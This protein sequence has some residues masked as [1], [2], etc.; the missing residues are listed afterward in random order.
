[1]VS[2]LANWI[3]LDAHFCFLCCCRSA[4]VDGLCLVWLLLRRQ[5]RNSFPRSWGF[6]LPSA[7]IEWPGKIYFFA[8]E[9]CLYGASA[10]CPSVWASQMSG[11]KYFSEFECPQFRLLH[12]CGTVGNFLDLGVLMID[13]R[14]VSLFGDRNNSCENASSFWVSIGSKVC[15]CTVVS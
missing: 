13:G 6:D 5:Y 9:F 8:D 7:A 11:E 3:M 15:V 1:M 12:L 14:R 2:G 10:P 4:C